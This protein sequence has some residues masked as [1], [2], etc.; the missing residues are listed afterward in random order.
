IG[1]IWLQ[2]EQR[3]NPAV[4]ASA[5]ELEHPRFV[6]SEPDRDASS[7]FRLQI[8]MIGILP[9]ASRAASGYRRY[10]E[11]EF[12]LLQFV[13][14]LRSVGLGLVDIREIVRLREQGIPPPERVIKLLEAKVSQV[15]LDLASMQA[16]RRRLA[17]LL[18]RTR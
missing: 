1:V 10:T 4:R 15:D 2:Q 3:R 14:Q 12:E 5:R 7:G 16:T 11:Q 6:R 13:T 9:T 18:H 17:D 8:G